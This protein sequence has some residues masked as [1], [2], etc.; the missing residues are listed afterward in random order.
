MP[1]RSFTP[2]LATTPR[3]SAVS[4]PTQRTT[5]LPDDRAGSGAASASVS[6]ERIG[7]PWARQVLPTLTAGTGARARNRRP[8]GPGGSGRSSVAGPASGADEAAA[9]VAFRP[10]VD[11][12]KPKVVDHG[13]RAE[14]FAA[15]F[16]AGAREAARVA[17]VE[18]GLARARREQ[19][20]RDRAAQHA[21]AM[22]VLAAAARAAKDRT[23]P[24][25]ARVEQELHAAALQLAAAVLGVELSDA[26]TSARAA[27]ARAVGGDRDDQ[28]VV[29]RLHPRDLAAIGVGEAPE[30]VR[31]VADPS[32]APGD[33]VAEHAEGYLDARLADA[34]A[35]AA[36][37]LSAPA[38][39]IPAPTPAEQTGLAPA[40]P[41]TLVVE[42]R[43]VA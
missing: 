6:D 28:P 12:T 32:L 29:V 2:L 31:L 16:A 42:P 43:G 19:D 35:R 8:G 20:E 10:L 17:E 25:V 39:T 22:Q 23:A 38:P 15:G 9:P 30:G 11:A 33:A 40:G 4:I 18:A 14:G 41:T 37:A 34:L 13:A 24:V 26:A 7:S 1:E 27:L 5:P 36:A 21:A 3:L